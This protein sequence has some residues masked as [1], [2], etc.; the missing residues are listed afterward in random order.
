MQTTSLPKSVESKVQARFPDCDPFN[1]LNNSKYIDYIINAREDHL[2]NAYSF[3]LHQMARTTGITWVVAQTNISYM[4]PVN[5]ME[6][7]TI[8]TRLLTAFP[9]MLLMEAVMW[10]EDKTKVKA[11][12]WCYFAHYN[13]RNGKSQ[14]HSDEIM[15]FF[16][17]IGDPI[18]NNPSFEE[19]AKFYR[20]I[21]NN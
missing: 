1:H 20:I 14:E 18:P 4:L 17:Q 21:N 8:E 2:M 16:D 9:K 11:M 7:V 12:M 15:T 19:R 3:D 13:L 10:N 6:T 5:C